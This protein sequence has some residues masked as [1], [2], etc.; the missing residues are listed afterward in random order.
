MLVSGLLVEM[1][2]TTKTTSLVGA[3]DVT[4]ESHW[5]ERS[6]MN[7]E[8]LRQ[9]HTKQPTRFECGDIVVLLG[10]CLTLLRTLPSHCIV[11]DPPFTMMTVADCTEMLSTLHY[12]YSD[13]LVLT[14]PLAGY[15]WHG[16]MLIAPELS[17]MVTHY[18]PH[19]RPLDAMTKLV[20]LTTGAV[21][22]PYCGSGTT[23]L[24]AHSLGRASI[25][26]ECDRRTFERCC[27]RLEESM[28]YGGLFS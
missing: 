9:M 25:G 8:R 20:A 11:T 7:N 15:I 24:A 21:V 1:T 18:H 4:T 23:L 16:R 2:S 13:V 14:N 19:Q 22:D 3:N 27:A 28:G 10:D 26:I 17:T 12:A 6:K 5:N